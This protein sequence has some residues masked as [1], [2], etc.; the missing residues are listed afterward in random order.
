VL[1]G[2]LVEKK[3]RKRVDVRSI[4][5]GRCA[6]LHL[7]RLQFGMR[8]VR[9]VSKLCELLTCEKLRGG[10]VVLSVDVTGYGTGVF[11]MVQ[12]ITALAR[13]RRSAWVNLAGVFFTSGEKVKWEGERV[14]VPKNELMGELLLAMERR[15][16]RIDPKK[17]W[18]PELRR[19]LE[20][21]RRTM[22]EKQVRWTT[23]GEHDDLVIVLALAQSGRN[24]RPLPGTRREPKWTG[25][26]W[27]LQCDLERVR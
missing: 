20:L 9:V 1:D 13:K 25:P 16:L 15:E 14:H 22:G 11:E 26:Q 27:E 21:M 10:E 8:F 24:Y 2:H 12:E 17:E 5:E 23:A 6:L 19:E 4:S 3:E 18:T 7:K